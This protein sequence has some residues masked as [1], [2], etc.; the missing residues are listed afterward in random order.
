MA[1]GHSTNV[2]GRVAAQMLCLEG[3][4]AGDKGLG[5]SAGP[6]L[7]HGSPPSVLQLT[8][9]PACRVRSSLTE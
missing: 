8:P 9:L 3:W 6:K 1:D 7:D 2:R 4:E 5:G